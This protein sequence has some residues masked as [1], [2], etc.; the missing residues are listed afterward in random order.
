ML[1]L[2]RVSG[3]RND[4]VEQG[5]GISLVVPIT[6][7]IP[8]NQWRLTMNN[9]DDTLE[10][11][12]DRWLFAIQL[13][14]EEEEEKEVTLVFQENKEKINIEIEEEIG[15]EIEEKINFEVGNLEMDLENQEIHGEVNI[16]NSHNFFLEVQYVDFL[17]VTKFD[18][19]SINRL[20]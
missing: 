14:E 3:I 17:R 9:D 18:Y 7:P 11:E 4:D 13:G 16:Q 12:A 10:E 1:E 8:N 2:L 15:I 6:N 20:L 5:V 19:I